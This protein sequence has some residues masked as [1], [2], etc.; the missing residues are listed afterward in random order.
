MQRNF[1]VFGQSITID[2]IRTRFKGAPLNPGFGFDTIA[3]G[4]VV[5]ISGF[6]TSPNTVIATYVEWKQFLTDGSEVELRGIVSGYTPPAQEFM[7]DGILVTF[8]DSTVVEISGGLSDGVYVE[9][10]GSY[11]TTGP[12]VQASKIEQEDEDFGGELDDVSLQ[13][14]ISNFNG[15]GDFE[16]DGLPVDAS[17]A[18]E[19]SPANVLSLLGEGVEVEIE[20]NIVGGKLIAEEVELREGETELRTTVSAIELP[21][22][23]QVEYPGQP[24]GAGLGTIWINTGAQTL[25]ED[26]DDS[27]GKTPVENFSIE[28]LE[29]GNFVD[30]EGIA[31]SGEVSAEIVRRREPGDSS[32]LQGVVEAY[33]RDASASITI[34]GVTY[35]IAT[36]ATY[37]GSNDDPLSKD[38][39]F[40]L[41]DVNPESVVELEDDGPDADADHVEFDE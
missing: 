11:Q 36:D 26:D 18:T 5:E 4:D 1:S 12:S 39:F 28:L 23:F 24:L 21:N 32:K 22:R 33:V 2:D 10:E 31:D 29:V 20:G 6:R 7:L 15:I 41:L 13:G 19:F 25:F 3:N 35:P 30:I 14:I 9:V 27:G 38:A 17:M 8:D 16:I 37:E 40:D 34:L